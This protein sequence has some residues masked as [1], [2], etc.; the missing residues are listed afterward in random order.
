MNTIHQTPQLGLLAIGFIAALAMIALSIRFL[1]SERAFLRSTTA[2]T[3]AS[4]A[5]IA[6]GILAALLVAAPYIAQSGSTVARLLQ[7]GGF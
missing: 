2:L 5:V 6:G 4:V 1:F 3:L 7:P